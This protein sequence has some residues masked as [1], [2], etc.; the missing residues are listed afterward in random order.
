MPWKVVK[1]KGKRPYKI[2]NTRT[3][4][5]VGSSKSKTKAKA[6]MRARYANTGAKHH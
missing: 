2:K 3:G 6:S 5:T 1:G 4:K